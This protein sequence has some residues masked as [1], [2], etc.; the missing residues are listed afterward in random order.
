MISFLKTKQLIFTVFILAYFA[1]GTVGSWGMMA[2]NHDGM[3]RGGCPFMVGET[4]KCEMSVL[5]HIISWQAMFTTLPPETFILVLFVLSILL[6]FGLLRYLYDPPD[7]SQAQSRF[8]YSAFPH[9]QSFASLLLGS[10]ISP[11]AP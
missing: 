7:T 4:A 11:R 3:D 5:D 6:V 2:M 1:V 8:P 9:S 10:A